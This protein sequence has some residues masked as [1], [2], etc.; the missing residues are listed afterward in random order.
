MGVGKRI[1]AD[2]RQSLRQRVA[3]S[4]VAV[5]GYAFER[6]AVVEAVR[7]HRDQI[8]GE[9]NACQPCAI[10]KQIVFRTHFR[11]NSGFF[12]DMLDTVGYDYAD[13]SAVAEGFYSQ[14]SHACGKNHRFERRTIVEHLVSQRL[15]AVAE[16]Y[17]N[18]RRAVC[19]H[20]RVNK[21]ILAIQLRR[22]NAAVRKR[23][24]AY[25]FYACGNDNL[26]NSRLPEGESADAFKSGRQLHARHAA[27]SFKRACADC[28]HA[29]GNN[30][31]SLQIA[32]SHE[33][34]QTFAVPIHKPAAFLVD[35]KSAFRILYGYL[36][37]IVAITECGKVNVCQRNGKFDKR[38]TA[39]SE[40]VGVYFFQLVRQL[41]QFKRLAAP[42]SRIGNRFQRHI[43]LDVA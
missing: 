36:L 15:E 32:E 28:R 27:T 13:K 33:Q 38:Q 21:R 31:L 17:G 2:N 10:R 3:L 26:R 18:Q 25:F 6:R 30:H 19:K 35:I 23:L 14:P 8:G 42:E 41:N 24:V 22:L 37:Q 11:G 20:R 5:V 7:G 34:R 39:F 12:A 9:N 16:R 1:A 29:F 43:E 4:L 40:C